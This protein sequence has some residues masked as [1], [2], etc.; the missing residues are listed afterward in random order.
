MTTEILQDGSIYEERNDQ[1]RGPE[2]N[3]TPTDVELV[4]IEPAPEPGPVDTPCPVP[5]TD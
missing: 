3:G 1:G 5:P 2:D 4:D